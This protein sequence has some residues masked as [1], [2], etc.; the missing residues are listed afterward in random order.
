MRSR[1]L[2]LPVL[3][4][5]LAVTACSSAM[6]A[7]AGGAGAPAPGSAVEQFMRHLV[8][9]DYLAM[10]WVFGTEKGPI[11]RRDPPRD[12]EK[13]MHAIANILRHES[14]VLRSQSPVPGRIGGAFR[15]D[16]VVT[17]GGRDFVVPFT[18]VR[19]PGERWY[20]EDIRLEAL[21]S[22]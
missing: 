9:Q 1:L 19:G 22:R 4:I 3:V 2:R 14:Y 20:I 11:L 12:V 17:T 7:P 6:R 8:D 21:T 5:L 13:R 10:G 18:A 16:V 15:F